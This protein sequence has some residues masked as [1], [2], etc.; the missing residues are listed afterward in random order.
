MRYVPDAVVDH[1]NITSLRGILLDRSLGGRL[2]ASRR[3][4]HWSRPRRLAH[5]VAFPLAPV[6]MTKRIVASEGW[7]QRRGAAPQGTLAAV[8]AMAAVQSVGEALGYALGSGGSEVASPPAGAASTVVRPVTRR[9]R[10]GFVGCGAIASL[11]HLR[12]ARSFSDVEI[13]GLADPLPAALERAARLA[14][15]AAHFPSVEQLLEGAAPDAVV[16]ATPSGTHS[17]IASAVLDAGAHLYLEKPI[18]TDLDAAEALARRAVAARRDRSGGLQ[19]AVPSRRAA[20]TASDRRGEAGADRRDRDDVRRAARPLVDARV[21]DLT[22]LRRRRAARPRIAPRRRD[23]HPAGTRARGGRRGAAVG[24]LRSRRRCS[25][26]RCRCVPD[27]R[28]LL[29][30]QATRRQADAAGRDGPD[31]RARPGPR[32]AHA[33]P[34]AGAAWRHSPRRG[35]APSCAPGSDPSYRP[36]LRAFVDCAQGGVRAIPLLATDGLESVRAIVESERLA[37]GGER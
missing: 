10:L 8:L 21:E 6:V 32:P 5:A 18:A 13:V 35:F 34:A 20:G 11:V 33:R 36:A 2:W 27:H 16:V 4:A 30:R 26:L 28:R 24:Q 15:E 7:R 14:P 29:V 23:P 37:T 22:R 3:S 19:Q 17:A 9:L 25:L 1:V 31:A 12:S